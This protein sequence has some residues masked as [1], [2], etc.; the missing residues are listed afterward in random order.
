MCFYYVLSVYFIEFAN[1]SFHIYADVMEVPLRLLQ[2]M[3]VHCICYLDDW[4]LW[5]VSEQTAKEHG[6][7]LVKV[8]STLGFVVNQKKSV[9]T[10]TQSLEWL[11]VDW[12]TR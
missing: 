1:N 6:A 4:L 3:G 10:P 11:G 9:L 7:L 12:D 8:L 5:S 2:D